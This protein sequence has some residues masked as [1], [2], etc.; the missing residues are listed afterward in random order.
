MD[1]D[2]QGASEKFVPMN[3]FAS[4]LRQ[5]AEELGITNAEAAR[6]VGLSER[7]YAN[8]V[9]GTREPNLATLVRIANTLETSP[10][11]LLAFRPEAGEPPT[12]RMRLK[13]RLNAAANAIPEH[14]LELL[15]VQ[16]EALAAAST[17][18]FRAGGRDAAR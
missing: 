10:D 1:V 14:T 16:A 15:T 7:R 2:C 11:W 5:R 9:S 12:A 18:S 8:Y 4:R 13:E 17:S 3:P 6:R